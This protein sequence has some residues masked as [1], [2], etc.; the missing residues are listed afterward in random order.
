MLVFLGRGVE[1]HS[2]ELQQFRLGDLPTPAQTVIKTGSHR[3]Y[4]GG[5][6]KELQPYPAEIPRQVFEVYVPLG[7]QVLDPFCGSG[8]TLAV[9]SELGLASVGI[10]IDRR[11]YESTA[12][13]LDA[14][15]LAVATLP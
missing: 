8:T 4:G 3:V 13:R 9:A 2:I 6:P 10:E 1:A 11:I 7:G 5:A 14:Q 12:D 15:G